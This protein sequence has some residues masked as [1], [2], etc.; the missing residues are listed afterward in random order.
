MKDFE[1]FK[2]YLQTLDMLKI[3]NDIRAELTELVVN[4]PK[5]EQTDWLQRSHQFK[6]SMKLLEEYHNWLNR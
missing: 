2:A 6:L 5:D 1:D 3:E 4:I